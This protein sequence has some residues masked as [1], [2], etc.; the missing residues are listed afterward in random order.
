MTDFKRGDVV[1]ILEQYRD[2]GDELLTWVVEEDSEKGRVTIIASDSPMSF[3]PRYVVET[4]W[5]RLCSA[6]D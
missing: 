3:K 4:A 1:E 6:P 5:I 2:P